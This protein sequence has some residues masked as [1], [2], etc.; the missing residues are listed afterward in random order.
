LRDIAAE[1]GL[2]LAK[3][4]LKKLTDPLQR[5]AELAAAQTPPHLKLGA[6]WLALGKKNEALFHANEAYKLAWA[7]GEPYVFRYELDKAA[8]L[9]AELQA[10]IP[11]LPIRKPE[12]DERFSW[13]EQLIAFLEAK[14]S[15]Q[16]M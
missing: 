12:D 7:D 10:P 2:A 3:F 4:R 9:L 11:T 1:T 6:L 14:A 16:K 5:A 8:A 13:E 15:E